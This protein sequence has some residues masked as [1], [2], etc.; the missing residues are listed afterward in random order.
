MLHS[1]GADDLTAFTQRSFAETITEVVPGI[2]HVLGMGH[3]NAVFVEGDTSVILIDTLDTL[4]RGQRLRELIGEKTHKPVKTIIYTHIHPDHRGGAGAFSE[5][6][7]EIIAFAPVHMPLK[8]TDMVA[9]IL[10]LRGSRQFGYALT[11]EECISQ[12]IG[13]REGRVYGEQI[14]FVKPTIVYRE[15]K[16]ERKI[17]GVELEMVLI[18][19]ETDDQILVWFPRGHVLCCADT[20]YGCWPNLYAIRGSQYRDVA[21]W[22]DSLDVLLSYPARHLLPGHTA[23]ISGTD[24]IQ[25]V[26]GNYRDAILYVLEETLKGMNQG[27]DMDTLAAEIRLPEHLQKLPYLREYY[28]CVEWTVRA[29]FTGYAGWFDGNPTHLHPLSPQTHGEKC[30]ALMGGTVSVREAA[31]DA[32]DCGDYQWAAELCD[33]LLDAGLEVEAA[34][35]TKAQALYKL[36]ELETSANGRHYYISCAKELER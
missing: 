12:G 22:V 13:I 23:A 32:V 26:L 28:G 4:E 34:K 8:K 16:V 20:Y 18:P 10:N 11:D 29:V 24:E 15:R 21:T 36:A 9:D 1:R 3:S 30:I 27:K 35:R 25:E 7:P 14:A 2:W 17:D 33:L 19:G 5:D 6:D 31:Y